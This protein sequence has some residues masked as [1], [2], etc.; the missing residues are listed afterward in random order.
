M[1]SSNKNLR[2]IIDDLT[3]ENEKL[4]NMIIKMNEYSYKNA[5][6]AT[7]NAENSKYNLEFSEFITKQYFN[8][9]KK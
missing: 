3:S 2:V 8:L 7:I 9:F 5:Q 4:K 6:N 1:T